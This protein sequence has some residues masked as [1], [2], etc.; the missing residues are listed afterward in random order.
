VHELAERAV[1]Y[2]R[3]ALG[4]VL[5][6]TPETLPVL[7]HYLDQVPTDQ[8]E[9][10]ALVASSAGAYFGEV[11]R[12]S[13]GGEWEGPGLGRVPPTGWRVRLTGG[14]SFSPIGYA[15]ESIVE[16]EVEGYDGAFDVPPAD[17]PAVEQALEDREVPEDEYYSL[18]GRLETLEYVVDIVMSR[19]APAE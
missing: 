14:V 3:R 6:Y 10:V 5:D 9:T 4:L 1:E 7:D 16:A 19:R 13:L 18:S 11:T 8:P 2:V 17:R 15:A 12:R